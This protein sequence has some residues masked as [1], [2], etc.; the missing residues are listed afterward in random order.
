MSSYVVR[1]LFQAVPLLLIITFIAF[2]I[3]QSTGDPLAAYT[4]EA[5]LT[6]DDIAR[7][8]AY[9]G[10]DRPLPLQYLSWLK[11][12]LTGNWGTSYY[13]RENVVDMVLN[14]LPNTLLLVA[15]SYALTLSVAVIV[16][17]ATAVRQYSLFD[18]LVTGLTFIG[19]AIPNFWLGLMLIIVFSVQFKGAG[20]PYFPVGGMYDH[21]VGPSFGQF[22][23]HVILPAATLSFVMTAQYIRYIRS[24]V[25]EQVHLDY[26]RTA[27]S[28]GLTEIVV[29]GRHVFKNALLPLITLI[30]LDVPNILSG[31]IVIE[32]IF[33]WP[34]MGRLFWSA[35][36]RTDI[37]VLMATLVFVST[38]TVMSN[39]LA[40][41]LYA[42][43]DP[44]IRYT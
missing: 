35:A 23:W 26:V 25:I 39:M 3:I 29:L 38:V 9:Y 14:R 36:E 44:R 43:V 5:S 37:P 28:K 8:R 13:T 7:L 19:I 4:V 41:L 22:L 1:R 2:G 31:T 17:I 15:V 27:R 18:H 33:A 16:G 32:S 34:G 21:R 12:M 11:N 40:D 20:L 42:V 6:S 10:L 24:S 30:A